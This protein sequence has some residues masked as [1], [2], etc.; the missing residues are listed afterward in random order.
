MVKALQPFNM[1][2]LHV[3][4]FITAAAITSK[5]VTIFQEKDVIWFCVWNLEL[6]GGV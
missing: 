5:I 6:S 4:V 3:T 1:R 2:L